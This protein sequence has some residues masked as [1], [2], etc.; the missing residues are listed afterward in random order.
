MRP[1]TGPRAPVRTALLVA[2][3]T[4]IALLAPT[5]ASAQST[6]P[7]PGP[8]RSDEETAQDQIV[9]SGTV[10]VPRGSTAGEVV[11]FHGR[12]VVSGVAYGDV[13]VLDGSVVIGGL[14]SGS[15]VALNGPIRLTADAQVGGDVLGAEAVRIEPGATV[16][17]A[18]RE[19]VGFTLQGP[20]AVLGI[21]LGSVAVGVSILI[22]LALLLTIAPRGSD[23]VAT[24]AMTAPF[25]SAGWGILLALGLPLVAVAA[26]VTIVGL[27]LGLAALLAMSFLFLVGFAYAAFSVGR[28]M[29]RPPRS[30]WLAL[31]AGWGLAAAL[32][33]VPFL[34]L[35]VWALGGMFGL[36]AM[37]VAIWRGR[38]A[39]KGGRHRA[40]YRARE[41]EPREPEP[42]EPEPRKPEPREPEPEPAAP[43]T[44]LD[45]AAPPIEPAARPI[46]EDSSVVD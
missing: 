19:T 20:L 22:L 30:R 9:L 44:T 12:A 14:V 11:V 43:V 4:A 6:S 1:V 39:D 18:V 25:A 36:G 3:V 24:A 35:A 7:S 28:L 38:G 37:S 31:L 2:A 13:V 16:Q 17:G 40:G 23:R 45:L 10:N 8:L 15:V 5:A 33:L 41:P 32:G 42:R 34:N 21:L 27:P 29:V 46:G 26:M